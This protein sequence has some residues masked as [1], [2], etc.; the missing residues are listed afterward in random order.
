[1]NLT[2]GEL[3]YWFGRLFAGRKRDDPR[4]IAK[5]LAGLRRGGVIITFDDPPAGSGRPHVHLREA[6][7]PEGA[8]R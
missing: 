6:E 4:E 8:K 3:A 5:A 7:K 1:M 2:D